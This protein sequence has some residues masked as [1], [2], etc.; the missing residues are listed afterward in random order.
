MQ[1]SADLL[2]SL[3]HPKESVALLV[4]ARVG[5]RLPVVADCHG[6]RIGLLLDRDLRGRRAGVLDD[7]VECFLHDPVGGRLQRCWERTAR[8]VAAQ[9][10]A[11]VGGVNARDQLLDVS[12]AW[13][14]AE[15]AQRV[16]GADDS[17]GLAGLG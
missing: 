14:G 6:E 12:D 16:G 10:D 8:L 3:V 17:D 9:L 7:V 15:I 1:G 2:G 5:R 11:D 4:G 13:G